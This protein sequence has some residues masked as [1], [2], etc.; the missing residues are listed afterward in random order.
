MENN[1]TRPLEI[2]KTCLDVFIAYKASIKLHSK[3]KKK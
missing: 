1:E 3:K 2:G